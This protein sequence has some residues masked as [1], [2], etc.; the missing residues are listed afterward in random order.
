MLSIL[1]CALTAGAAE[2]K[3]STSFE[4]ATH[5]TDLA[6]LAVEYLG[7]PY[8][9]G[10]VTLQGLDCGAFVQRLYRAIGIDLPRTASSQFGHGQSIAIADLA[11]GDLIFFR[12][13]YRRGVSHVGIYL[14]ASRFIHAARRGVTIASLTSPYWSHR[15]AGGRRVIEKSQSPEASLEGRIE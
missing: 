1:A 5:V 6:A 3:K 14:G 15:F 12:N 2:P 8:R 11:I 4:C 9:L 7:T 10:G 13:T